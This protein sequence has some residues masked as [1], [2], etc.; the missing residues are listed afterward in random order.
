MTFLY[1]KEK[2]VLFCKKNLF[3]EKMIPL[4]GGGGEIFTE[5]ICFFTE[6]DVSFLHMDF[7]GVHVQD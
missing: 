5:K 7:R 3:I 6:I 1:F 4:S 2:T